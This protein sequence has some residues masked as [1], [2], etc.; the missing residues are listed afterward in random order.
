MDAPSDLDAP[1]VGK[2]DA[3]ENFAD[4]PRNTPPPLKSDSLWRWVVLSMSCL[5]MIGNY[6]CFDNPAALKTQMEEYA[7]IDE[8]EF[9]MLYTVYSIPNIILPFFGGSSFQPPPS[10]FFS[11]SR[12][13]AA[14]AAK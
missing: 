12:L 1:L 6:Y 5:A 14:A 8:T 2:D 4:P 7:G 11:L 10:L 9:N 13:A 3:Q